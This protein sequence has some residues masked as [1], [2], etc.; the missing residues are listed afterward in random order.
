MLRYALTLGLLAW[1]VTRMDWTGFSGLREL[2]WRLALP[3]VALAGI[4]YPLQILRWHV[5]LRAQGFTVPARD[6]HVAGWT[7]FFYNSFL[8]GGIAGDAVRFGFL[9]RHAPGRKTAAAAGLLADRL[10]GLAALLAWAVLALGLHLARAGDGRE[11]WLLLAVMAVALAVLSA[12]VMLLSRPRRWQPLAIRLLGRERSAALADATKPLARGGV[13]ASALLLS[14]AVWAADFVALWLLAGSVDL[15]VGLL[16]ISAAAAAAYVA[17]SLPISIGGHGLREGTLV[18]M[19]SLLGIGT[20]QDG[21]VA[22]LAL[23]FFAVSVGWSLVGGIVTL[24]FPLPKVP[25]A[26]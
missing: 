6:V 14:L 13:A 25:P 22:L 19:L 23:S 21:A 24:L 7:G 12:G 4:A 18:A 2:D 8:P 5:L 9:W 10:I 1:L 26:P 3:A 17:A 20:G 15:D 11:Q 16:G